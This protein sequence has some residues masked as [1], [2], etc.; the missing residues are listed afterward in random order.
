MASARTDSVAGLGEQ[1]RQLL[2]ARPEVL[3]GYLFGSAARGQAAAHSDVDVA[4]YV[5]EGVLARPGFGYQA[6]LGA[7]L[8]RALGRPD[9]DVVIL[10]RASPLLYHR[11]LRDGERVFTRDLA[12][13]TTREGMALSRYCDFVPTLRN[14]EA[15]H[16]ARIA[17]GR[18]G[19]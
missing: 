18:F 14:V 12:A 17:S 6:E 4:V 16:R 1:V 19:R 11:V 5:D 10:N 2:S 3:D 8:Q 7:D 15:L 9:V 13:T